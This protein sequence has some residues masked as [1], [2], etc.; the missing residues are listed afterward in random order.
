VGLVLLLLV[1]SLAFAVGGT[2]GRLL[3]DLVGL[4]CLLGLLPGAGEVA[5]AQEPSR[6]M[7]QAGQQVLQHLPVRLRDLAVQ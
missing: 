7:L 5:P 2:V 4:I 6:A 1:A 3:G